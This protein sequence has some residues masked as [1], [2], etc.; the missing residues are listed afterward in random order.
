MSVERFKNIFAGLER[1]RG[2]TYV[3]K[4]GLMDRRLKVNLCCKRTCYRSM[5]QDMQ[6]TEP[7]L[8]IIP[9]TD[10]NTCNGVV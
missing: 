1:A 3:D 10:D 7:S 9:I 5:W 4:K 2:V 6:G 8:G